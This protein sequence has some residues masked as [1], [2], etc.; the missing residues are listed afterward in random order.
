MDGLSPAGPLPSKTVATW[1][2]VL[3]GVLGLHRFYLRGLRDPWG[4]VHAIVTF[5]GAMGALRMREF[6]VDD[7]AAWWLLPWLGLS[8]A[9]AMLWAIVFGLTPDEKWAQRHHPQTGV[10]PT[11]WAPVLGVILALMLGATALMA[12]VAFVAQHIFEALL[13]T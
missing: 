10:V 9:V 7:A 11:G 3:G 1:A 4:W 8:I 12:T 13:G 2:A 5:I 6:G